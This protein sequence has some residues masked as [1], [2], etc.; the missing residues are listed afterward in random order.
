M[1][2]A[3]MS[4]R[5]APNSIPGPE[6]HLS[7]EDER[8]LIR[9]LETHEVHCPLCRYSLHRLKEPRC[10]ECNQPLELTV[11]AGDVRLGWFIASIAPGIFSGIC[12]FFLFLP[13]AYTLITQ[14]GPVPFGIMLLDAFGLGSGA[15]AIGLITKR[16]AFLKQPIENQR[17]IAI[18]AWFVHALAFAL[19]IIAIN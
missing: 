13:I 8:D 2:T 16:V 3:A 1:I 18:S 5:D 17:G 15:V 9:F 11:G 10:P 14:A 4:E 7:V 19:L 6:S 12:G